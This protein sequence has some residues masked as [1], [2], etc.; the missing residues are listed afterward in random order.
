VRGPTTVWISL[1]TPRA[2]LIQHCMVSELTFLRTGAAYSNVCAFVGLLTVIV[3]L[4][5]P[6][7][8]SEEHQTSRETLT[9]HS[10]LMHTPQLA[11][12]QIEEPAGPHRP[13]GLRLHSIWGSRGVMPRT[14]CEEACSN[15]RLVAHYSRF[16]W[17]CIVLFKRR[18]LGI[19]QE[20]LGRS[21]ATCLG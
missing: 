2:H 21:A 1:H 17:K 11:V 14:A 9:S 10:R 5:W 16:C 15:K 18:Q 6:S 20:V 4:M 3:I 7:V 13:C 8:S 19:F 12:Q